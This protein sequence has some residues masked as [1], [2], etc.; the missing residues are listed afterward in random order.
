LI[1]L[2]AGN[3]Y[4]NITAGKSVS[5][6]GGYSCD[7]QSHVG[8]ATIVGNITINNG[9]VHLYYMELW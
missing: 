3:Y 2:R 7:W 1:F 9:S 8:T 4:E 6:Y 5:I